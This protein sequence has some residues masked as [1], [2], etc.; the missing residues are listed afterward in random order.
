MS[1]W[2]GCNHSELHCWL[3]WPLSGQC[4]GNHCPFDGLGPR[5]SPWRGSACPQGLRSSPRSSAS[6]HETAE[7]THT[8]SRVC[9]SRADPLLLPSHS[10]EQK[11]PAQGPTLAQR[12]WDTWSSWEPKRKKCPGAADASVTSSPLL[13]AK[14]SSISAPTCLLSTQL[15]P[16]PSHHIW[17]PMAHRGHLGVRS[18]LRS[19]LS[20]EPEANPTILPASVSC[21]VRWR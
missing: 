11:T 10:A 9:Q 12:G 13:A 15:P 18:Q 16:C 4:F 8:S 6:R 3:S 2:L 17:V 1:P 19:L 14:G 20:E 7:E 21:S 5:F